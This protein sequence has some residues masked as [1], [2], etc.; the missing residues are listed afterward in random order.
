MRAV[1]SVFTRKV[2]E[3]Y[4]LKACIVLIDERVELVDILFFLVQ[5]VPLQTGCILEGRK[6]R[7]YE[8]NISQS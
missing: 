3:D 7:A 2:A 6:F 5:L 8:I 4:F 1:I